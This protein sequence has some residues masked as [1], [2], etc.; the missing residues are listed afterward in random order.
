MHV[1]AG[2]YRVSVRV[3]VLSAGVSACSPVG[4]TERGREGR[5]ESERER[6]E[7]ERERERREREAC[8]YRLANKECV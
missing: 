5:R 4:R 1:Q 6:G 8:T 3:Q 7:R 2:T